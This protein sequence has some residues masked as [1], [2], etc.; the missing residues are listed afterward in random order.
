MIES[1]FFVLG[2]ALGLGAGWLAWREWLKKL[3][4]ATTVIL[5]PRVEGVSLPPPS[6]GRD[7]PMPLNGEPHG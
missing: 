3:P 1:L 5:A 7:T 2:V 6:Y 4:M